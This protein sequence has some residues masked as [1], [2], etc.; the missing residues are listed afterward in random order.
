MSEEPH[1]V[2]HETVS[3]GAIVIFLMLLFYMGAGTIIEKYH[4]SFGHEAAY[5]ILMG[6]FIS[7]VLFMAENNDMVRLLKFSDNTFFY[8]CLPPIV[9]A[10]GF[11]M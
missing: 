10:S 6:M 7:F 5:S 4:L 1:S 8:F 3:V 9:F 11:N 2:H